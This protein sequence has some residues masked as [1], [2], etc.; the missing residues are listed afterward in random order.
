MK[1]ILLNG[2]AHETDASDITA[3][4]QELNLPPQTVLI[5][6]N[7]Q[8]LPRGDWPAQALHSG[9]RIEILRIAAGG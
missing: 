8:A 7:G 9:D 1:K 2:A 3:L 4:L 5:E 6:Q